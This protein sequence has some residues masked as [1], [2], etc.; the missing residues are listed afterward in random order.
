MS[1]SRAY[2]SC[3]QGSQDKASKCF[4]R[5]K[6]DVKTERVK[7]KTEFKNIKLV[8]SVISTREPRQEIRVK[9]IH[10]VLICECV[11]WD[12]RV[13]TENL[14]ERK[15]QEIQRAHRQLGWKAAMGRLWWKCPRTRTTH[16]QLC[17]PHQP[18]LRIWCRGQNT[19]TRQCTNTKP[20]L[21]YKLM[22]LDVSVVYTRCKLV[23]NRGLCHTQGSPC[24]Q[25]PKSIACE[26]LWMKTLQA[27]I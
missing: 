9:I 25:P 22:R 21:E 23:S 26:I 11:F 6:V 12:V 17:N 2:H 16:R 24:W 13:F 18:C 19:N 3:Q 8:I 10:G 7:P 27:A 4:N 1:Q 5:P 20:H 15:I 14:M